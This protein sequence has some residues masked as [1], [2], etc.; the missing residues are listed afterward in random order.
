MLSHWHN[1]RPASNPPPGVTGVPQID[2]FR[3]ARLLA[4]ARLA[5]FIWDAAGGKR[6]HETNFIA[7][8]WLASD[9]AIENRNPSDIS[10]LIGTYAQATTDQLEARWTV[11]VARRKSGRRRALRPG[12]RH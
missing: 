1:R 7:G 9:D 6:Q 8:E 4:R 11:P 2:T 5:L 3:I 10:D 12:R